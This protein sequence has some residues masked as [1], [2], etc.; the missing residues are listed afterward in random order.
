M[1]PSLEIAELKS[2]LHRQLTQTDKLLLV[3]AGIGHPTTIKKIKEHAAKAGLR[4]PNSWNPS[5]SLG[6]SKGLAINTP[7]GWELTQ[8]GIDHLLTLGVRF[9]NLANSTVA[10]DLRTELSRISDPDTRAFLDEAIRCY[11]F[12]LHRSAVIMTWIGAISLLRTHVHTKHLSAFNKEAVRVD[13]KWKFAKATD[14]FNRMKE[15]DF[16]DRI[17]ALSIIG[18]N[19]KNRLKVCLDLRNSCGHPNSLKV[20]ANTAASHIEVLLLNVFRQF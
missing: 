13:A 14:D 15:G 20:G 6:R 1:P 9:G 7:Q 5:A 2:W 17:A 18:N 16:L 11:E 12:G 10:S 19:V 4:I 8:A 3:L